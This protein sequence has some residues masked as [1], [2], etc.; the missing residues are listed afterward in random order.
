[1]SRPQPPLARRGPRALL[2]L[3]L[4]HIL[5][6]VPLLAS[7]L[8]NASPHPSR[9][10]LRRADAAHPKQRQPQSNGH[11]VNKVSGNGKGGADDDDDGDGDGYD[12]DAPR[13]IRRF[14]LEVGSKTV[15]SDCNPMSDAPVINGTTP[16]PTIRVRAGERVLINVTN[17]HPSE[18]TTMHWHG[19]SMRLNP[20]SDGTPMISQWTIEPGKSFEYDIRL[21]ERE[22]GTYM[23]HTH[24][25]LG[26]MTAYG[27]LIIEDAPSAAEA[28]PAGPK[29][30]AGGKATPSITWGDEDLQRRH[31][32]SAPGAPYKYHQ[33][34]ILALGDYWRMT[35]PA[36]ISAG[37]AANPFVWP[38]NPQSLLVNGRQ[39]GECNATA[40]AARSLQCPTSSPSDATKPLCDY[41]E[42]RV[43]YGKTYR[44]R[45]I[46]SQTLM[47]I[48]LGILNHTVE[49][50][51]LE[52]I[53]ADGSYLSPAPT[54][55]V[56]VAPGQRYS[57][58]FRAKRRDEVE[59]DATAGVYWIRMESR[60]R[61]GPSGWARLVYVDDDSQ[62]GNDARLSSASTS[63][64]ANDATVGK[65]S[66][67]ASITANATLLP[68]EKVGWILDRLSPL[69]GH[70]APC[71]PD[72]AVTRTVIINAQQHLVSPA[73]K[74]VQWWENGRAYDEERSTPVPYLV[75]LYTG[76]VPRPSLSRSRD[77]AHVDDEAHRL[78]HASDARDVAATMERYRWSQGFDDVA[79]VY[80]AQPGEVIDIII[81]NRPSNISS[82]VEV[83]PWHMHASK[84]WTRL[85][86]S[87]TFSFAA[88]AS[89]LASSAA[90][91]GRGAYSDPIPRD[92]T[93]VYPSPGAAYLNQT[94]SSPQD[95]D[96][97][98]SVL[99][100]KVSA[101]NAGVFPLHCHITFHLKMG[102]AVVWGFDIDA[103]AG[104]GG[105][106]D[107]FYAQ[108]GDSVE[109]L[110]LGYLE[111][112]HDVAAVL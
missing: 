15:W 29:A 50:N 88:Y 26:S 96:G 87:G 55:Y 37:L 21:D 8:A 109:G 49:A 22:P 57:W 10:I 35:S 40:L 105:K 31:G 86:R 42:I 30:K 97:G 82:N 43:Q 106:L 91:G 39:R 66:P 108:T 38:G 67:P 75:N 18:P 81:I 28:K 93:S 78:L 24:V 110:S 2:F 98:W 6:L 27:A 5:V 65:A 54:E 79:G 9:A 44:F 59:R 46:G 101:S 69:R 72:S 34:R 95:N 63:S 70:A 90:Q 13:P 94:V 12:F 83:H 23:Y 51:R 76:K 32:K 60:W 7:S 1:M 71:P 47:Y 102:M 4:I 16:G 100:Y 74:A 103:F 17:V 111:P 56:E 92:T 58:L 68:K 89:A 3:S 84:H 41:P 11:A 53:E 48:S 36:N 112:G 33:D 99:R 52:L 62:D 45:L 73:S 107:R 80:L 64:S 25:E 61:T 77:A 20:A 104:H 19:L 14:K 85:T